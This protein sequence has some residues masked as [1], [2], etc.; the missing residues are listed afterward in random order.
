[1]KLF[2]LEQ[3]KNQQN[4]IYFYRQNILIGLKKFL[5]I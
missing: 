5:N 4:V 3:L 1:M 2:K